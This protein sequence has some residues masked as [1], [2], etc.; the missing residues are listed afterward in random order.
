MKYMMTLCDTDDQE[1]L[2]FDIFQHEHGS[3]NCCVVL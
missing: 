2:H 1:T 3:Y